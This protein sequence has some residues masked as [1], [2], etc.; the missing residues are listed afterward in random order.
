MKLCV[1]FEKD[2]IGLLLEVLLNTK[3][4]GEMDFGMKY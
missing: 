2:L 1:E 3:T 4:S